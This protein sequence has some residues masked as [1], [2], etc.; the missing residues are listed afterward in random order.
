MFMVNKDYQT[1][2][3][4]STHRVEGSSGSRLFQR[5]EA[6]AN[7]GEKVEERKKTKV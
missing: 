4:L 1:K 6:S 3:D 2:G 5:G 7:F